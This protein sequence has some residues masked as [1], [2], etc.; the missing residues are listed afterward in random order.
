[1]EKVKLFCLPCAGGSAVI[2][3][4]WHKHFCD[5]FEVIPIELPGRGSRVTEKF[6]ETFDMLIED[7]FLSIKQRI[8]HSQ[9]SL[10]GFSMGGLLAYEVYHRLINSGEREPLH[11]FV[12]GRE[13]PR[14]NTIKISHLNDI[15]FINEVYS[16]GGISNEIYQN[17]ELLEFLTPRIRADFEIYEKY[18]CIVPKLVNTKLSVLFSLEDPSILKDGIYDW[19]HFTLLECTFHQLHGG[20]FFITQQVEIVTSIIQ[21]TLK[22]QIN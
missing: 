16:Y 6:S 17:K 1:M 21:T 19:K 3:S 8:G 20:H 11:L 18:E 2:Y 10:L 13:A 9:Y 22:Q 7:I 4:K 12:I 15:D 5:L 14:S